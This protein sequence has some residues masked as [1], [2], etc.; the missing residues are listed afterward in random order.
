MADDARE[1]LEK[2]AEILRALI[3]QEN[4]VTNHRTTW[5]LVAQGIL[6]AAASALIK[7]HWFPTVVVGVL[8]ILT[9]VS[10]GHALRNS[11]ESRVY[12]KRTWR[13]RVTQQGYKW[14]DFPPLDGGNPQVRTFNWLFPWT[15]I[16]KVIIG[17]WTLLIVYSL[18]ATYVP[19]N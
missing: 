4:D 3:R 6:F 11:F 16:P 19:L 9:A 10:I 5:L 15:F 8:G 1:K 12:L 17:A 14:E 18:V 2:Y 13:E 7:I